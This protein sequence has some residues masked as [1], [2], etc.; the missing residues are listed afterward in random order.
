LGPVDWVFQSAMVY[1]LQNSL[2]NNKVLL[3][4]IRCYQVKLSN[5]ISMEGKIAKTSDSHPILIDFVEHKWHQYGTS[6]LITF[7]PGKKQ[8]DAFSGTWNRDLSKDIQRI[9]HYYQIH[10]LV[11]LL[12]E[13]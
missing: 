1:S 3:D 9:K 8:P 11:C 4:S 10:T 2:I 5:N 12:E 13:H 6:L 7:A